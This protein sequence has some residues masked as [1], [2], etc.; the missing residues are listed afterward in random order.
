MIEDDIPI[1]DYEFIK[2]NSGKYL[3]N[4]ISGIIIP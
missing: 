2:L 1:L 4:V 3:L